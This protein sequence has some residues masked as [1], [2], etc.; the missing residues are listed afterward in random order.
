MKTALAS[1]FI[2]GYLEEDGG[3][4]E[5]M[6]RINAKLTGR[7]SKGAKAKW[8]IIYPDDKFKYV[9]EFITNV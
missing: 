9:W 7:K 6:M 8:Y 5:S 1:T 3:S 2:N 4:F